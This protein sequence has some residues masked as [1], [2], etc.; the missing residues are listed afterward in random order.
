VQIRIP[1]IPGYT[2]DVDNLRRTGAFCA[3]LGSAVTRVQILPYHR[4]GIAKYQR[5]QKEYP[6]AHVNPPDDIHMEKCK[7]IIEVYGLTV[8]VH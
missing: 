1:I 2:D 8:T 7:L 4:L 5:L 3:G 6:L